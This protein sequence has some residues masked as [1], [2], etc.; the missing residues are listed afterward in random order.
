MIYK[1][2]STFTEDLLRLPESGMGY[3]II[4]AIRPNRTSKDRFIVYNSSLIVDYSVL[5]FNDSKKELLL[6]GYTKMFSKSDYL[7]LSSPTLVN[8]SEVRGT[9]M[10]SEGVMSMKSRNSGSVGAVDSPK[11][12]ANGIDIYVRL[13]HYLDD[14]RI[15]KVNKKLKPG[16]YATTKEDYLTC[17]RTND[18]PVDR[19]ALPSDELIEWA[20]E[21]QPKSFDQLRLGIAQPAFNHNGGGVEALFDDGTSN[22]TLID[23][24]AY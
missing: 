19:Y 18:D 8:R 1:A 20:F 6:E 16:A 4:D 21:V 13:S 24:H 23:T 15:D 7:T 22:G 9:R 3:Q 17:K 2:F 5:T 14:K 12:Y 11:R 10:Y